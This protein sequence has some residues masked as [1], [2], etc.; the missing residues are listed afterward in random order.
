MTDP[1]NTRSARSRTRA[2]LLSAGQGRRLLPLT[3]ERPKCLLNIGGKTILEWQLDALLSAGIDDVAVV[4]GYLPET[5]EALIAQ[6]Y[7]GTAIRSVF[8]P[9]FDITDNLASCWIAREL[10][11]GDFVLMNGDTVFEPALLNAVLTSPSAPITLTIDRKS[12]YDEDDMKVELDGTRVLHVS[13]KLRLDHVQAESIGLLYFRE[14]GPRR[15]REGVEHALRHAKSLKRFYL[16]VVDE[17][18]QEGLV[19]ACAI[20]G[21][22]WAE[23]DFPIDIPVAETLFAS[24]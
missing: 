11:D 18:A 22:R 2:I 6:R 12:T 15:F 24:A 14:Q 9:F 16:A 23:I 17:L 5:V 7:A 19:Q 3:A 4:T 21:R 1:G 20:S 13:K 10:M 8:N